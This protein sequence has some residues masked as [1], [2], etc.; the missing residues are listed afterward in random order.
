M[1]RLPQPGSDS[2][3]WGDILNDFLV[4]SHNSDGTLKAAA[5]T[6]TGTYTKPSSGIPA[7]DL[8]SATQTKLSAVSTAYQKPASGIPKTDLSS[9]VQQSLDN[10]DAAVSGG[11][12]DASSTTKG[13]LALAG[14]LGGTADL[15]TV[16]GLT[17]KEPTVTPGTSVQYYR[18]DKTWQTLDKTA[19]GL[20]NV[21]NTSD[22]NKPISTATQT[23][24]TAKATDSLVLHKAGAETV[25]GAK[26][27]TGGIT[28]NSTG[29]VVAS[30]SRL[31]D[32]R[33][34]SDGSVTDAKIASGGLTNAAI[35]T[36]A[37]IARTKLDSST[38]TSLGK[39]DSSVQTAQVGAVSGVAS[40]DGSGKVP[41]GQ[42]PTITDTTA[43]HQGDLVINV[44][45]YGAK[46][47][48]ATD[49]TTPIQNAINASATGS[50]IYFPQGTYIISSTITYKSSRKY[51]GTGYSNGSIIKQASGANIQTAMF[52]ASGWASNA[53]TTGLPFEMSDLCFDG[54]KANNPSSNAVGLMWMNWLSTVRSCY[55]LNIPTDGIRLTD[56]NSAGTPITN[57]QVENRIED[58]KFT[59][60]GTNGIWVTDDALGKNTD[61]FLMNCLFDSPGQTGAKIDRSAGWLVS[62]NHAYSCG[63]SGIV[64]NI[65]YATR[66]VANYVEGFGLTTVTGTVSGIFA[67]AS[68]GRGVTMT[69][70][71][72]YITVDPANGNTWHYLKVN[73]ATNPSYAIVQNNAVHGIGNNSHLG[74]VF[75]NTGGALQVMAGNNK[76]QGFFASKAEFIQSAVLLS[77]DRVYG[78]LSVRGLTTDTGSMQEWY[79]DY[80]SAT[81]VAKVTHNG[82]IDASAGDGLT[83]KTV[84]GT[85]SD[86]SFVT[87]PPD[88]TIV[89][90][91]STSK[92][93]MRA[94][95][96]WAAAGGSGGSQPDYLTYNNLLGASQD[97]AG[98][99]GTV[100]PAAGELWLSKVVV[101]G[102]TINKV[103]LATSSAQVGTG[104]Q[105]GVWNASGT[106]RL[107]V[108]TTTANIDTP[109]QSA[110]ATAGLI[111]DAPITGLT[112]G[113]I[114]Y[115]GVWWPTTGITTFPA[116]RAPTAS[117]GIINVTLNTADGY[118]AAKWTGQSTLPATLTLS[119]FSS[120]AAPWIGVA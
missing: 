46:G 34:P 49:D 4:Q 20:A 12:P 115:V 31:T 28:V 69:N 10:A 105:V 19:V 76:H 44:K 113:N 65:A 107:G 93:W 25:T 37:A 66:I 64:C 45:N 117:P 2:N 17:A 90:D 88:G 60:C 91:T 18:G 83:T 38:Q 16:P 30:D 109:L 75:Q 32:Q 79:K 81:P 9:A 54:N 48:G 77:D 119:S 55:F 106:T 116:L 42:L 8:D 80:L 26:D 111:L 52:A 33:T 15:P 5:V 78:S 98:C 68:G 100:S 50:T 99:A 6:A 7:T 94:S 95:G 71:Q 47:D 14:D 62:G 102:T 103:V 3:T 120:L 27:F 56:T 82:R 21:D 87:A 40:L 104:V 108:G 57:T 110:N 89:V 53:T 35:S 74:I 11:V 58:C 43:V 63:Y 23:A 96:A 112:T 114:Y 67:T 101:Y 22:A 85:P 29:V 92:L 36:T 97:P 41:T 1:S 86:A 61:G 72:V 51:L 70:N 73:G 39:A 59:A 13:K 24:L 118:R 84:V